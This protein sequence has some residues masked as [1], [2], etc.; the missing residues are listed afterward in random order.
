MHFSLISNIQ[1]SASASRHGNRH[2]KNEPE[3]RGASEND[4]IDTRFDDTFRSAQRQSDREH[5][6]HTGVH[7]ILREV[8]YVRMCLSVHGAHINIHTEHPQP[9]KDSRDMK[10]VDANM[11]THAH[12]HTHTNIRTEHQ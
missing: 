2:A 10:G 5:Q 7:I 4:V 11:H 1:L 8:M 3:C 6:G 9:A 12:T